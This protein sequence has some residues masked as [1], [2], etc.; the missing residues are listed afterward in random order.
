FQA[1]LGSIFDKTERVAR[2]A[3]S[4][5]Q[6]T[7][8]DA[9]LAERAGLLSKADLVTEMVLEFDTMQ[10]IAG[11]YYANNDGENA[12]VAQALTEQYLPKFAGDALPASATGTLL[13]LADRLD[14]LVGI[15]G[16]G[17]KPTGSKDPFALRRASLGVLRL[18]VEKSLNLDLTGLLQEAASLHGSNI[19][20]PAAA[21]TDAQNYILERF[22]AWYEEAGIAV[23]V[24][25]AVAAKQ[26]SHPLDIN[27]RVQAVNAFAAMPE[28]QALAA[29]NKRVSN[30]LGKLDQQPTMEIDPTHLQETAEQQLADAVIAKTE[31]VAPLFA[32]RR[33][34]E[35]L[36]TLAELGPLVDRFFD[37]VMVMADDPA[38][39]NNRL[40][41]LAQLRG[42]FL[43]VADISLLVPGKG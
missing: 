34:T 37:E 18:L 26:L 9:T 39:R 23:E 6:Q 16:I 21:V 8:A 20:N 10:G 14:T 41:L 30:I 15:F 33:Y 7:G 4:I 17:Q 42:L 24:Y 29:A 25:L 19:K 13:A 27:A 36:A 12:E 31:Q 38:V 28:A 5:A 35:V 2:L 1:S 43:Q 40:A 22:R 3:A 11:F 32:E